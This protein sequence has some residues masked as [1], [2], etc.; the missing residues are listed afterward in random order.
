MLVGPVNTPQLADIQCYFHSCIHAA[1][2]STHRS[3]DAAASFSSWSRPI[4]VDALLRLI[5]LVRACA[6]APQTL[7]PPALRAGRSRGPPTSSAW[8]SCPQASS[9]TLMAATAT[10]ISGERVRAIWKSVETWSGLSPSARQHI[11]L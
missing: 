10:A 2:R 5:T 7:A 8:K 1:R 6:V 11:S 4:M 9:S 3:R